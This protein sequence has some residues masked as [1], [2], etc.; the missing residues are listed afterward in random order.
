MDGPGSRFDKPA[1]SPDAENIMEVRVSFT[2]FNV[3][4]PDIC[5][6]F[7]HKDIHPAFLKKVNIGR[8]LK[9]L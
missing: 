5:S 8:Y 6:D 7:D 3:S 2:L 9:S 1:G 4:W